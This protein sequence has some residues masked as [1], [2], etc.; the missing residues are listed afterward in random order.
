M[1]TIWPQVV[2]YKYMMYINTNYL[3]T[4]G[5]YKYMMYIN[6]NYLAT[7]IFNTLNILNSFSPSFFC[8]CFFSLQ[9]QDMLKIYWMP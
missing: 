9:T 7:I 8:C 4:S 6:T 2:V 5:C 3:A 1:Q